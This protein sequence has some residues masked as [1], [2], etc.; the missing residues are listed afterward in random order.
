MRLDGKCSRDE[1]GRMSH[2]NAS[3][4]QDGLLQDN[5]AATI[6]KHRQQNIYSIQSDDKSPS[7]FSA[8]IYFDVRSVISFPYCAQ[9]ASGGIFERNHQP[10]V[11]KRSVGRTRGLDE[12][13]TPVTMYMWPHDNQ[14]R[15]LIMAVDIP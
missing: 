14:P 6:N 5:R 8:I 15:G 4:E 11:P 7:H 9:N 1:K 10:G 13:T 3:N 12:T 2:R